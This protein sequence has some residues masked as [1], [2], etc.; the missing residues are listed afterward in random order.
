[1]LIAEEI[2]GLRIAS[3]SA[4]FVVLSF[5]HFWQEVSLKA[6]KLLAKHAENSEVQKL[7]NLPIQS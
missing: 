4:S 2:Q 3:S 5:L 6:K 7:Q 1:M